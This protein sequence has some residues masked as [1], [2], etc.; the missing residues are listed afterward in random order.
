M[1]SITIAKA[2]NGYIIRITSK[3]LNQTLFTKVVDKIAKSKEELL[4]IVNEA[5]SL[6]SND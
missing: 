5:V 3:G 6:D 2:A 1:E 4:E